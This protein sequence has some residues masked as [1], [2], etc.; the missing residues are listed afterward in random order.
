MLCSRIPNRTVAGREESGQPAVKERLRVRAA[1]HGQSMEAELRSIL[2]AVLELDED[3][4]AP[5]LAEAIRRH[6]APVGGVEL[7]PHPPVPIGWHSNRGV[8]PLIA[9]IALAAGS[10]I[11]TRDVGGFSGCGLTL[12]DPWTQR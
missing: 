4:G 3:R 8:R 1:R 5:N 12:I 11:A 6:F 2:N 7:E 9:A 10:D